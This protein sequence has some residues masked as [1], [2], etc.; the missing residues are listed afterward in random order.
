MKL[1]TDLT[2]PF[3]LSSV[4]QFTDF[5]FNILVKSIINMGTNVSNNT[6]EILNPLRLTKNNFSRWGLKSKSKI[7]ASE[8]KKDRENNTVNIGHLICW[9][10][11]V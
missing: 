6:L 5:S 11:L 9:S 1:I 2:L 4:L 7:R 8:R 3:R 10:A